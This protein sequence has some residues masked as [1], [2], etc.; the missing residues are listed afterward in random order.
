M[1][2]F[3][4][5]R[6]IDGF[7]PADLHADLLAHTLASEADFSPTSIRNEGSEGYV[8]GMRQSWHCDKALGPLKE[9]FSATITDQRAS[10]R[11]ALGVPDFA[12]K[13][14]EFELVAH[15]DGAFFRPHIDTFTAANR[16]PKFGDRVLTMVYYFHAQP[17]R[18]AGGGL[19]LFAFASEEAI[20]IE[21][22]DNRLVAFPSFAMHEVLPVSVPDGDVFAD[23]R[24]AVNVWFN[25]ERAQPR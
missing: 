19:K 14:T 18:F 7:L 13:Y 5:Y 21:P 6:V 20:E 10:L 12:I 3:P 24:F 22:A 2:R 17:R 8:A 4:P 16:N 1:T 9:R 11:E 15:R 23:A 25:R